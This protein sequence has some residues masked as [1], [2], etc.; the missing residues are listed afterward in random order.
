MWGICSF[1]E[2]ILCML[3][4]QIHGYS[5]VLS[6][7]LIVASD[8]RPDAGHHITFTCHIF[9]FLLA[10]TVCQSSLILMRLIVLSQAFCR[11][12]LYWN[13]FDV[14][15]KIRLELWGFMRKTIRVKCQFLH[16]VSKVHTINMICHLKKYFL[17]YLAVPGLSDGMQDLSLWHVGSSSV[18]TA[19]RLSC[20]MLCGILAP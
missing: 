7:Y 16:I 11:M 17:I 3:L 10:V 19:C 8:P 5:E 1:N 15:L 4:S 12:L 2:L 20:P 18:V 14:F 6:L 13:I 9:R